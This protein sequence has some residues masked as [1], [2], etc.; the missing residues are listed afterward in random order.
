MG[1]TSSLLL[2]FMAAIIQVN[3][4]AAREIV[5]NAVGDIMLAGSGNA[6]V[7]RFGCDHPFAATAGELHRGD[8]T[9]GNLEAPLARGGTEFPFKKFR[10]R[11]DPLCGTALKRAGFSVLTLANNHIM[12]FGEAALQETLQNLKE[13]GILSTGAGPSLNAAREKVM[14]RVKGVDVAFLA[15]SLTL[16]VEFF[17]TPDHAGTA[18]GYPA[19]FRNDLARAKESADYVVVSFHWGQEGA[20]LPHPNQVA[21]AHAAIDAGADIVL[22]HHPHVLQG[23]EQYKQGI[24]FYS[25]GNFAFGSMSPSADRSI[26]ARIT[27][28][29]GI[30]GVELVP[31]NVLNS[32]VRFQP[33]PL[34]GNKG[35]AAIEH[36][37]LI[38]RDMGTGIQ[39][40]GDRYFVRVKPGDQHFARYGNEAYAQTVR[41][42]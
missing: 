24:I 34:K 4:A 15:Y 31:I 13:N 17:S 33:K 32:E 41:S 16:P 22:G 20:D 1:I 42:D 6:V 27:L 38:S 23:I 8:I 11:A 35:K 21:T 30:K 19:Y 3:P 12:D 9:V 29:N 25:L 14:L 36:L 2:L 5:I 7:Q 39:S 28:D 37:S 10:F 26:I 18:P 40:D